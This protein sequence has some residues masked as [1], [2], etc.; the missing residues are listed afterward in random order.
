MADDLG[1]LEVGKLADMIVVSRDP[2]DDLTAFRQIDLA[3]KGGHVYDL[4]EIV[5]QFGELTKPALELT[6][7]EI[8]LRA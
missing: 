7:D 3:I 5:A 8:A 1:T 4:A 6:A 2:L